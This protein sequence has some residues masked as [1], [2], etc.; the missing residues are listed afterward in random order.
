MKNATLRNCQN[1]CIELAELSD[2]H[3]SGRRRDSCGTPSHSVINSIANTKSYCSGCLLLDF[4]HNQYKFLQGPSSDSSHTL[5][6]LARNLILDQTV[7]NKDQKLQLAQARNIIGTKLAPCV[8]PIFL[9]TISK[10]AESLENVCASVFHSGHRNPI[11]PKFQTIKHR[12][13]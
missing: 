4:N 3:K 13:T 7:V 8:T 11:R 12:T 9:P 6:H 10:Y 5:S 2:G 1:Y